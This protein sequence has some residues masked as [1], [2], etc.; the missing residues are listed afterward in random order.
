MLKW[1]KSAGCYWDDYEVCR[2]AAEGGHLSVLKWLR[3]EGCPWN[4]DF[5]D[6]L[7]DELDYKGHIEVLEWLVSLGLYTNEELRRVKKRMNI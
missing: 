2:I 4:S 1:L 3:S 5:T 7:E 6:A